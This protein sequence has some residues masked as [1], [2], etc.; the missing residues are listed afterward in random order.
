MSSPTD[1][2]RFS[3]ALALVLFGCSANGDQVLGDIL[4]QEN[5]IH[6]DASAPGADSGGACSVS[7]STAAH[8]VGTDL[9]IYFVIDRSQTMLDP[10]GNKWDAFTSGF[11]HF[12]RTSGIDS[13][14]VGVGYFPAAENPDCA[15]CGRDC[16]CLAN[17]GC[18]CDMRMDPRICP[19]GN[20]CDPN[21][22]NR[23]DVDIAPVSQNAGA[24][25]VSLA[26]PIFGPP[27]TRP[28]LEGGLQYA[29]EYAEHNRNERVEVVLVM[30]G[31]PSSNDC[32]P[33]TVFDCADTA[34]NSNTKTSVI[35]FDYSGP[36]LDPIAFRGGGRLYTFDSHRDDISARLTEVVSNLRNE[37]HC[38]YD[39]PQNTPDWNRV[40]LL[41]RFPNDAGSVTTRFPD[42]VK[43]RQACNGGQGW[44]YDRPDHP[45]RIIAC[46]ATCSTIHG[47]PEGNVEISVECAPPPP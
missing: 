38:Q 16:G 31:P 7:V 42:Q 12:L 9:A 3:T 32:A 20:L 28:A 17:C 47:P 34:G 14:D 36:A 25:I 22:Y 40:H 29:T 13:L 4:P 33:D 6:V 21:T 18:P 10:L 15:R 37:P 26:Q 5:P 11:T 45:T 44:Y 27:V 41:I 24:L 35:A 1:R 8:E 30:G 39:F 43:S 19:R 46:D 23:A 2:A